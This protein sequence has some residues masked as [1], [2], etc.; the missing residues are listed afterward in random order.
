MLETQHT[1]VVVKR[2]PG[3]ASE[4]SNATM[5]LSAQLLS[6]PGKGPPEPCLLL[7]LFQ[8]RKDDQMVVFIFS[9]MSLSFDSI[10]S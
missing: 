4:K 1:L 3:W 6:A 8:R 7:L 9:S 5:I 2:K 10:A